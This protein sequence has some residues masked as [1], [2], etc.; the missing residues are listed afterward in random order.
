[1]RHGR[2]LIDG[3]VSGWYLPTSTFGI[4]DDLVR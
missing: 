1:L 4:A 3:V 2:V